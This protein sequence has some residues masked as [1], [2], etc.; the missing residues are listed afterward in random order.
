MVHPLKQSLDLIAIICSSTSSSGIQE[1]PRHK[2]PFFLCINV[3]VEIKTQL[4][5][6]KIEEKFSAHPHA[7][8]YEKDRIL[9]HILYFYFYKIEKH[10]FIH[11]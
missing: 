10:K 7:Q 2:S 11:V 6:V 8:I 4:Q 3:C 9:K 1:R 5:V